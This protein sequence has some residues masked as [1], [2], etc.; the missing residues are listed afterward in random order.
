MNVA[1][2]VRNR[3]N[4]FDS[5]ILIKYSDLTDITE[6]VLAL[7][8]ALSRMVKENKLE[9]IEKGVFYKPKKSKFGR[10]SPSINEVIKKELEKN[11]EMV[12]Y[13]T[14]INLYNKLGLTTQISNVIEIGINKRKASKEVMGTKVKFIQVNSK[15]DKSTVN[16][17]QL[18]DAMKSIKKIPDSNV[19][20]NYKILKYKI[21]E[22]NKFEQEKI[23]NLALDY[24]PFTRAILGMILE[25]ISSIDL[26][27]LESSLNSF[28]K[29]NIEIDN[30]K[31]RKRWNI[32]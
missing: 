28:T 20:E 22:L 32:S 29:F 26:S 27:V 7:S 19:N 17:L 4:S 24:S 2:E 10:I 5:G 9:K 16:L 15:I 12:G 21:N 11:G 23:I 1:L 13:I 6:N 18:L 14:G 25:E 3:I 31:N 8:K 30:I